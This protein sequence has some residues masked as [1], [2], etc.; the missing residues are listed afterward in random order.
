MYFR[1]FLSIIHKRTVPNIITTE[2]ALISGVIPPLFVIAECIKMGRVEEP[3]PATKKV[4]TKSSS[5]NV[6]AVKKP[7]IMPGLQIG[8]ITLK[9]V[10]LSFAPRSA[11]ASIIEKSNSSSL[12][13]TRRNTNGRLKVVC[14][15]YIVKRP[16]GIPIPAKKMARDTPIIISGR[17]MGRK[18]IVCT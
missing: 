4:M 12:A 13:I 10:S 8:R 11:A 5:D 15:M 3:G 18:E 1:N 7:E 6:I 2:S 16:R 14:A 17:I 9:S